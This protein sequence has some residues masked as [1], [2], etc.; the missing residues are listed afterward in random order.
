MAAAVSSKYNLLYYNYSTLISMVATS[1][2]LSNII[3]AHTLLLSIYPQTTRPLRNVCVA[4]YRF[5]MAENMKYQSWATLGK[6]VHWCTWLERLVM[7]L[8]HHLFRSGAWAVIKINW[9]LLTLVKRIQ[10]LFCFLI[11]LPPSTSNVKKVAK[12]KIIFENIGANNKAI[13]FVR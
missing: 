8:C 3:L 6:T 4:K 9:H 10:P 11:W 1:T 2:E 13:I 12:N 7:Y 5:S